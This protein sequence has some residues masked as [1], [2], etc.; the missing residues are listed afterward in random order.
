MIRTLAIGLGLIAI[1]PSTAADPVLQ[2]AAAFYDGV[3]TETLPNGLQV[4][5]KPVPGATTVTTFVAYK[6]G[7]CDEDLNA[8][9]LAHYLEHL[10]FKGTEKLMPGDIDRMTLR[11]GG[12]NNAW[13]NEDLTTYHF[14]FAADRWQK[15]LEIEADRMRNLRIDDRHEF[16]QEKGAVIAELDRNEDN[17]FDLEHKAILPLLFGRTEPYGHPVIGERP[18]VRSA[19][20]EV[21]KSYYDRWYHPNNA[22]LIV[23][24]GFEPKATLELIRARLGSIPAGK[25]PE[26]KAAKPISRTEPVA[27]EFPS[28]FES[29]RLVIGYNTVAVEHA[30]EPALMVL[31]TALSGGR[32]GRLYQTL[33]EDQQVASTVRAFHSPGRH[34]GWFGIEVELLPDQTLPATEALVLAE[35]AKFANAPMSD[36]DL[37]RTKRQILAN[38]VFAKESIHALAEDLAVGASL[39]GLPAHKL[40][41]QKV[42]SV[43]AADVQRVAKAYLT[44]Q[45]RVTVAS[46]PKAGGAG[47]GERPAMPKRS[48]ARLQAAG[49]YDL[50]KTQRV[51]LP[52]GLTLLLLENHRLPLVSAQAFVR[53]VRVSE[54]KELA[55]VA[56][57]TGSLLDEGTASRSNR[58]IAAAIENVGGELSMSPSGGSVKVLSSD[59]ELGLSLLMDCLVNAKFPADAFARLKAQ[60]VAALEEAMQQPDTKAQLLFQSLVY[61]DH[62]LGRPALGTRETL[63][64]LKVDDCRS[65][66]RDNFVPD[67][68]VV[69]VVGDFDSAAVRAAI[70]K[71]TSGWQ[72][73][74]RAAASPPP[75]PKLEKSVERIVSQ[76]DAA[77]LYFY[78]GHAGI[79]RNDPDF[80]SLMVMDY[81]LGTGSGFT[82]R[83]SSRLRDRQGLAYSVSASITSAAGEEPG[84]FVGF[85]GTFPDKLAQV[86]QA[87]LEEIR[88]IRDE[89]VKAEELQ[90]AQQYLL[91]SI[92]F[93]VT[94]AGRVAEQLLQIERFGLGFS[95]LDDFRAKVA[96]VTASSVQAAAR[97]HLDPDRLIVV[98]VGAVDEQGRALAEKK[99]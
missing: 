40:F 39:R 59:L 62:P 86:R 20:A 9:G 51:V 93:R 77:Q 34:P 97:K 29:P 67:R 33:I 16:Q 32:T 74:S 18:H 49:A 72:S 46:K 22:V 80:Y 70:E 44:P 69:A 64:R 71:L 78:L 85:I 61:G 73:S 92:P 66:H 83:L 94:T 76:A 89:P 37:A 6:V 98:A 65:F 19:T 57:L 81:V 1:S 52:N 42:A 36:G 95:Y 24:G 82:D 55:G 27:Y 38:E 53:G 63:K 58:E 11:N 30:D 28:K 15:V 56:S 54:P 60:S 47:G 12:Q 26:R 91:G 7:A 4:V 10:M 99:P 14:D 79:R 75:L 25:L 87:F 2:A 84:V 48:D 8:T 88:R 43:T 90:D 31:A 41:L 45:S 23:A 50:T 3:I 13:T 21:I 5:L 35:V 68:T 17:P 96:S